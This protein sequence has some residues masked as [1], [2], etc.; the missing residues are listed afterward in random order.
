MIGSTHYGLAMKLVMLT[1]LKPKELVRIC[2]VCKNWNTN[3]NKD[4]FWYKFRNHVL[5][6]LPMLATF[7]NDSNIKHTF[8]KRLWPLARN[9]NT[10]AMRFQH[11]NAT[12]VAAVI[13]AASFSSKNE[14]AS[15]EFRKSMIQHVFN[16]RQAQTPY[17]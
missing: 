6:K 3:L 11:L 14:I 17:Q 7:F 1:S 5:E 16:K 15:L 4:E 9:L 12:L 8:I 10:T 2:T 13:Q